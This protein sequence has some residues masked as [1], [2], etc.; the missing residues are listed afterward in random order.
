MGSI[1]TP[2][3]SAKLGISISEAP[4]VQPVRNVQV[5]HWIVASPPPT[6]VLQE[7]E[8]AISA[9]NDQEGSVGII[10]GAAGGGG[11]LLVLA[12]VGAVL[13]KRKKAA[14]L[15]ASVAG[16]VVSAPVTIHVD[17]ESGAPATKG[18]TATGET[19]T[20]SVELTKTPLG[21]GLRL[22]DDV[23]TEVKPDSQAARGGRI[24]VGYRLTLTL[25]L[26]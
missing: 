8:N 24:K 14:A 11:A 3:L 5:V 2:T 4:V 13:L 1:D 16:P 19:T 25:N 20:Y 22:T 17:L 21:L 7:K 12:L 10:A 26:T 15:R 6:P 23:V 9:E 18:P